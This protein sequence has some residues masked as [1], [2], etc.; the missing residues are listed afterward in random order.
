MQDIAVPALSPQSIC[1]DPDCQEVQISR[2]HPRQG[3]KRRER[4]GVERRAKPSQ[5]HQSYFGSLLAGRKL[6]VCPGHQ[7]DAIGVRQAFR[8]F[9]VSIGKIFRAVAWWR[10]RGSAGL[11]LDL[12]GAFG[13]RLVIFLDCTIFEEGLLRLLMLGFDQAERPLS[14]SRC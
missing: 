6:S 12:V 10:S 2:T 5:F 4:V 3:Q 14:N 7:D 13:E 9:C 1:N 11:A 8:A